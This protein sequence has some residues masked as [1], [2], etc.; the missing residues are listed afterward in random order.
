MSFV[1]GK[2]ITKSRLSNPFLPLPW[3]HG[4]PLPQLPWLSATA[5]AASH[6]YCKTSTFNVDVCYKDA[7]NRKQL[8]FRY[9]D[10]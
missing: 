10:L 6:P 4:W 2:T 1:A 8:I 3:P 5:L 9:T 7:Y